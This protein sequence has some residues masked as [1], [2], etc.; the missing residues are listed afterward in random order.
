MVNLVIIEID[1]NKKDNI[2]HWAPKDERL[3]GN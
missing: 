1:T 3:Q 2:G